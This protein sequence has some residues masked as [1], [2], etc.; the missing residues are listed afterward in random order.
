MT[1]LDVG[2]SWF[3]YHHLFADLLQLELRRVAPAMVG[4]LHRAAAQWHEQDGYV[5]EA[6]RHAQ[7][8]RDWPLAARLLA[9]NHFDLTL[10]GRTGTVCDLLSAFP[11]EVAAA[12]V[13]LAL[14]F[15]DARLLAGQREQSA[16]YLDLAGA[17][18]DAVPEERR[19]RF[20]VHLAEMPLVLARWRGDL[21]PAL[22]SMRSLGGGAGG[23][24]AGT[25]ALGDAFRAVALQNLGDR[26]AVV[27]AAR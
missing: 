17:L 5:V 1:S 8:A 24:P 15:S 4:P 16:A 9:D 2:R 13:E 12:D 25:R 21:G 22:E 14:V 6:I 3:R 18:I 23:S 7:A 26:R 19:R 10:D 27:L 20:D 11:D